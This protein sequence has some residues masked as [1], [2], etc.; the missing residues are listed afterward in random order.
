MSEKCR[1]NGLKKKKMVSSR[2]PSLSNYKV[3]PVHFYGLFLFFITYVS[4][5]V[6]MSIRMLWQKAIASDLRA[7]KQHLLQSEREQSNSLCYSLW[8]MKD[9][10][11]KVQSRWFVCASVILTVE[12]NRNL[13]KKTVV[14]LIS[15]TAIK[16]NF[17]LKNLCW[18]EES[19]IIQAP[20]WETKAWLVATVNMHFPPSQH[21]IRATHS[22][23]RRSHYFWYKWSVALRDP[24]CWLWQMLSNNPAITA[25]TVKAALASSDKKGGSDLEKLSGNAWWDSLGRSHQKFNQEHQM[26]HGPVT[27]LQDL[28]LLQPSADSSAAQPHHFSDGA[29]AFYRVLHCTQPFFI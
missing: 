16:M 4:N 1:S 15:K 23:K 29:S 7:S 26:W 10:K 24:L 20:G 6:L 28:A 5:T 13:K 22:E 21:A 3:I 25:S 2:K 27:A 8:K 14:C 9:V 12:V 19:S 17:V 18:Q 11:S